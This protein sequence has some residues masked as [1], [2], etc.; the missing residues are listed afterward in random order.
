MQISN[1]EQ[2]D[3]MPRQHVTRYKLVK[4]M[5]AMGWIRSCSMSEWVD[6]TKPYGRG[7]RQVS[8]KEL[9]KHQF[10]MI[11]AKTR[12]RGTIESEMDQNMSTSPTTC[13]WLGNSQGHGWT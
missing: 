13:S 12:L 11:G 4:V 1:Q 3:I 9:H 5:K 7:A 2:P 6:I 8:N 10:T